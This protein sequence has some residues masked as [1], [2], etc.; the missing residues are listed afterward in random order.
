MA[1]R[2]PDGPGIVV[3]VGID[4]G[5][6]FPGVGII[7]YDVPNKKIVRVSGRVFNLERMARDEIKRD[8]QQARF[9]RLLSFK[10][11][12]RN[13][14][15]N[16]KP[17]KIASEHPYINPRTP[18]A[19]IPLAEC[20]FMTESA[21]HDY[22]PDLSL[23]KIDPSSIKKAVG[24]SG[25]SGDKLAMARAIKNIPELYDVLVDDIDTM[26]NNAVDAVAVTY[27]SLKRELGVPET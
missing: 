6:S 1:L 8:R 18:G 14:F 20:L 5:T 9:L 12:L 25:S 26:D 15:I 16:H 13:T 11:A 10:E 4:P 22:N 27:C 7:H 3:F 2:I 19:V 23:E 24:V 17:I 21:V